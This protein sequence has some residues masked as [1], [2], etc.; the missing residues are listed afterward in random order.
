VNVPGFQGIRIHAAGTYYNDYTG[1]VNSTEGCI[2]LGLT[3]NE[4]T[5]SQTKQAMDKFNADVRAL[6]KQGK[7]VYIKITNE[8]PIV[9]TKP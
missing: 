8:E 1:T 5:V 3:G 7:K 9:G 4:K 6:L 2:V